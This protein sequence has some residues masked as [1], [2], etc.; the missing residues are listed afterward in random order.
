M[1]LPQ[2]R[3]SIV[4]GAL[5]AFITSFDEAVVSFF[6]SGGENAT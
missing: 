3:F 1:T 4:T 6:I 5:F 2:I